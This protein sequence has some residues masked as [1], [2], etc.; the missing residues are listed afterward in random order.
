[1]LT[2]T[3]FPKNKP[4]LKQIP[5]NVTISEHFLTSGRSP[6]R[7]INLATQRP[8]DIAAHLSSGEAEACEVPHN[9]GGVHFHQLV[10]EGQEEVDDARTGAKVLR[11]QEGVSDNRAWDCEYYQIAA[12]I[13]F[14]RDFRTVSQN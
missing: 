10:K 5:A 3:R 8:K 14:G 2:V 9:I 12:A 6:G 4:R 1:L 13:I 7:L 11:W